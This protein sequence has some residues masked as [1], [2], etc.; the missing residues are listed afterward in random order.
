[1]KKFHDKITIFDL[2]NDLDI[3]PGT[4]SK[5]LNGKGNVTEE[6]RHR[7]HERAKALGYVASHSARV[8]K[9][10]HTW[11]IGVVFSDDAHFELVHPFFSAILQAFKKFMENQGYEIVF[12]PKKLGGQVQTYL[13]W[14]KNKHV[15]GVLVLTG[16]RNDQDMI[17]LFASDVPCVSTDI[18]DPSVVSVI[19]DDRQGINLM[20]GHFLKM[21]MS[22]IYA[23]SGTTLSRAYQYRTEVYE[24]LVKHHR[25]FAQPYAYYASRGYGITA[26]YEEAKIWISQWQEK[27][28]AIIAFSDDLAMGLMMALKE[29][30]YRIPEDISVGGYD[31]I[32]FAPYFSPALTTIRQN[33]VQIAETAAR[34]LLDL[35]AKNPV[36][37]GTTLIPVSLILRQSTTGPKS[38]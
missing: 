2:A 31:D 4:I 35:I 7:I 5:V 3:S 6:T 37:K 25:T 20:F 12:I 11:T 29:K 38:E 34:L 27:P 18:V 24:T 23:F 1:M 22:K 21:G 10:T 8:L 36:H 33:K 17:E 19:S 32:Q 26:S 14:A 16:N 28:E 15:D 13:Q 30:G 9:A